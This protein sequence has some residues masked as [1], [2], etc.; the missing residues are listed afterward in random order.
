M[1]RM[2]AILAAVEGEARRSRSMSPGAP[3]RMGGA[4]GGDR[5]RARRFPVN[6]RSHHGGNGDHR[7]AGG[8]HDGQLDQHELR[9]S[10][11]P[12]PCWASRPAAP[13]SPRWSGMPDSGRPWTTLRM[14]SIR[15]RS[16]ATS[17]GGRHLRRVD[18]QRRIPGPRL[19]AHEGDRV[20]IRFV[21]GSRHPHTIHFHGIHRAEMD[22]VPGIGAGIIDARG[23]RQEAEELVMVVN[24]FDTPTGTPRPTSRSEREQRSNDC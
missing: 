10:P 5:D 23:G 17:T 6:A 2:G 15:R 21:N 14:A 1:G 19:W 16:F 12:R 22:G 8:P 24:G 9:W 7:L 11:S 3:R 20:R 18:L 13:V 4:R